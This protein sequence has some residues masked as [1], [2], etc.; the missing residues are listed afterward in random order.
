VSFLGKLYLRRPSPELVELASEAVEFASYFAYPDGH[1][2]GSLGS[3]QTPHF[4]PHGVELLAD[5]IPLAGALAQRMLEGLAAGALVPPAIM[6][7]RYM[8]WRMAEYLLAYRDARP[9]ADVLPRLPYERRPFRRWFPDAGIDVRR[10]ADAYILANLAKGGVVKAFNTDTGRQ[11]Y[12]D[13]G[14][15]G[16]L[17]SGQLVSSQWIASKYRLTVSDDELVVEGS[18][19]R[20]TS[21]RSF[22][23]LK[24]ALF[25]VMLATVGRSTRAS[26][27]IKGTIRK[28]LMLG[29]ASVPLRFRRRIRLEPGAVTIVDELR[30]SGRVSA[31]GL[32]FGDEFAVRYVPQSRYF[33]LPELDARGYVLTPAELARFNSLGRLGVV[34]RV[35]IRSGQIVT[36]VGDEPTAPTVGAQGGASQPLRAARAE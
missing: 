21:T 4:Y 20:M 5:R 3:R 33:Q 18:L 7:D 6:P 22:T 31:A 35:E 13:C 2:A 30:R 32:M 14:I 1:Y 23:P 10:T 25:R 27:L 24:M 9:R 8:P 16:R 11:V 12:S 34:R 36:T 19:Q 15:I 26:H 17:E 29:T 28:M